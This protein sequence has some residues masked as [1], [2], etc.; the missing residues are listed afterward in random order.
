MKNIQKI[1]VIGMGTMGS[2]LSLNLA[3]HG[4]KTSIYNRSSEK[5]RN[6]IS[7]NIN[8]NLIPFYNIK[9]FIY[10]LEKPKKIILMVQSGIPT[11]EVINNITKYLQPEDIII[12]G[13]NSF[14]KDTIRRYNSLYNK[15]IHFVGMGISG[16]EEGALNGPAMMPGGD[17]K[18]YD[19][20]A[21]IFQNIAARYGNKNIPCINY[22]GPDGSGHYVK[23]IHNGI[24]Y[25]DMQLI[26]EIYSLLKNALNLEN[27]DISN[28]FNNWNKGELNSYLIEITAN[29]L[30]KKDNDK[31][32]LLDKIIDEASNKGT[33]KWTSIS[34]LDLGI[35]LS[36][37][38]ESLFFRYI[39]SLKSERV[40]ASKILYGPTIKIIKK[41]ITNFIENL[42]KALYLGKI[43]S[44]TQGFYQLKIISDKKKWNLNYA[45]I[46][47][48]F[49]SGCIIRADFL[50]KIIEA[51]K[52][53]INISNLLLDPY[54]SNIAD[55]YQKSLRDIV[56]YSVINGIPTPALSSAIFYYDSYRLNNLPANLIQAQRDYFG[57]HG[58]RR[59]DKKG[60][61]HTK[62]W[63]K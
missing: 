7:N 20:I 55:I 33:G 41:D 47:K 60:F 38:T 42:R 16:G 52:K 23:M 3:H 58:Y 12:D 21:P 31:E 43:I 59:I 25:G 9:D 15:K 4:Y 24:E 37:I 40:K 27:I 13:G 17:K 53:N 56:S 57:S 30:I 19:L 32:Y 61:F 28:I 5:T 22:I 2:N 45:N 8:K 50:N 44:Y 6:F 36:L 35:P 62:N 11:D 46:A 49:R 63:K 26:T 10:S 48:I 18:V 39:S 34:A 1:G 51:Y 14:Y 54:F 29:I